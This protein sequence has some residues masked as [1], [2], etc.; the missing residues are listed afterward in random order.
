MVE[1]LKYASGWLTISLCAGALG[2]Y[3]F[4]LE[5]WSTTAIAGLALIANGFLAAWE[6][7]GTFNDDRE[8]Q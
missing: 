7:R 6:D 5:F 3:V 1:R 4:D 8:Q 2:H